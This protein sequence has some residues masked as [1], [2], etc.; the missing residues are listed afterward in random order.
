MCGGGGDSGSKDLRKDEARR[1]FDMAKATRE[2]N[3]LFGIVDPSYTETQVPT[4]DEW[5]SGLQNPTSRLINNP[6]VAQNRYE[7]Y[8]NQ[9][10]SAGIDNGPYGTRSFG[11]GYTLAADPAAAQA[12]YE[13]KLA[14]EAA[15]DKNRTNIMNYFTHGLNEQLGD[16]TEQQTYDLAR[17]GL[18]KGSEDMQAEAGRTRRYDDS[19][20]R[21]RNEA[22]S[23]VNKLRSSDETARLNLLGNIRAGMDQQSAVAGATAA[24]NNNVNTA[25]N[26]AYATQFSGLFDDLNNLYK[27]GNYNQGQ[28]RGMVMPYGASYSPGSKV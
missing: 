18:L 25:S 10:R 26:A 11:Y 27:Q 28:S 19:L 2:I 24:L 7:D 22:D 21:L 17:R 6:G 8:I 12:A 15:Y 4:Y 13:N 16:T 9:L 3:K 5:Y 14:R 20:F 23:S 1:E